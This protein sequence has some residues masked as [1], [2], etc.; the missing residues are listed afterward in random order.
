M[1]GSNH[2]TPPGDGLR[3]AVVTAIEGL[4]KIL[5]DHAGMDEAVWD[6]ITDL[7]IK[8]GHLAALTPVNNP[9]EE[10]RPKAEDGYYWY[11]ESL[12]HRKYVTKAEWV[13]A[14][15][16][17]GFHGGSPGQPSTAGRWSSGGMSGGRELAGAG[18]RQEE[19]E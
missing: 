2:M 4:G 18:E 13:R 17:A 16:G 6:D 10:A 15:Q 19:K 14:E 11:L 12:G 9:P 7:K 8:V 3:E 5:W 1:E